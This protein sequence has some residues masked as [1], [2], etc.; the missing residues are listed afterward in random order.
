[1]DKF[2]FIHM[3]NKE[4]KW[5][6]EKKE[7]IGLERGTFTTPRLFLHSLHLYF[8]RTDFFSDLSGAAS[9]CASLSVSQSE[10]L[11]LV[12]SVCVCVCVVWQYILA[13]RQ[14]SL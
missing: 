11:V 2:N 3:A 4:R 1:M 8:P 14:V 9:A 12:L 7:R 6:E 5:G 13:L 10:S